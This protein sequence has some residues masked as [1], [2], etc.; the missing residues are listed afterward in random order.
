[1][2]RKF[3]DVQATQIAEYRSKFHTEG[4]NEERTDRL[5]LEIT[6]QAQW[7]QSGVDGEMESGDYRQAVRH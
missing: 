2:A 6:E 3:S 5:E 7:E 4:S 1:M